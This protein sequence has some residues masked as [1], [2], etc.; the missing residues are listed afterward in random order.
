MLTLASAL[1]VPVLIALSLTATTPRVPTTPCTSNISRAGACGA[2]D[3]STL[4]IS[5]IQQQPGTDPNPRRGGGDP[6]SSSGPS[7][8]Q[9]E[10]FDPSICG[11][12]S[13]TARCVRWTPPP[14]RTPTPT[15]TD[16][17]TPV[18]T[19]SD[20]ARF[21]PAPIAATAEPGNVGIAGMPTNFL[22]AASVQIQNG[23]LFGAPLTVRFT[24]AGY[25]YSYGDGTTA[26]R[27]VGGRTWADLG[28]AQFTP[29]PTS[30]VYPQRGTYT[31]E[32]DVRYTA[33][34]DFGTGWI[35]VAGELTTDGVD[36]QIRIFEARTALVARTCIEHPGA[37]GC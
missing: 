11:T 14:P 20:L 29:T 34:V 36:Q 15:S 19:I 33:E 35:S 22:G 12:V 26:T 25:D 28:Q 10:E 31:A 8:P 32:V 30:H 13:L 9:K 16:P 27:A 7:S 2:T 4:T 23:E 17:A 5:G 1:S 24:P 18:I 37:P 21:A 6:K 3:G